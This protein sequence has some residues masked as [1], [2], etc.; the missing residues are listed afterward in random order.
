MQRSRMV[1][2]LVIGFMAIGMAANDSVL[3]VFE[4]PYPGI[5]MQPDA[6]WEGYDFV[7]NHDVISEYQ[8]TIKKWDGTDWFNPAPISYT[9]KENIIKIEVPRKAI[10]LTDKIPAFYFK[11]A[12]N[13]GSLSCISDFFLYGDV[14]PDRRF[15]FSFNKPP[16]EY[17]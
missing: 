10:Q 3:Q 5:I 4:E 11:W 7:I 8:I 17:P 2:S 12:D 15:N 13:T 9:A 14:A 1:Y 16:H 6:S